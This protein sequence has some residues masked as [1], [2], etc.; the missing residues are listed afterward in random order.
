MC[1]AYA[2]LCLSSP[3]NKMLEALTRTFLKGREIE[4]AYTAFKTAKLSALETADQV[5]A[6]EIDV[7]FRTTSTLI[8][9]M[10]EKR[11]SPLQVFKFRKEYCVMLATIVS[12][13][14]E[15]NSHKYKFDKMLASLGARI[16]ETQSK[17][18][19]KMFQQLPAELIEK[20]WKTSKK[21]RNYIGT[22]KTVYMRSQ[23]V[24]L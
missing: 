22:V 6:S 20:Q 10:K 14:H 19:F 8:Q 7:G 15:I 23:A 16:M 2:P 13:I 21:S 9:A 4:T 12:K 5:A 17:N 24:S 18:T 11:L 3:L 1:Q